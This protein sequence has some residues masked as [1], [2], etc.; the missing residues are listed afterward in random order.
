MKKDYQVCLTLDLEPDHAGRAPESFDAWAEDKVDIF[1][2]LLTRYNAK[3]TAFVVAETLEKRPET[4]KQ[5]LQFGTEFHLH[6]HTHDLEEYDA[7]REIY[8][9]KEVYER[10]F[11]QSPKGYRAPEGRISEEGWRV[12]NKEGF[13]FDASIYPSF[14]PKIS[15]FHYPREPFNHLRS[16][17]LEFPYATVTPLRLVVSLSWIKLLGWKFYRPLLERFSLPHVLVFN[18][19]LHDLWSLPAY[20]KLPLFWKIVYARNRDRGLEFLD[21]FLSFIAGKGCRFS[22]IS[23]V[24]DTIQPQRSF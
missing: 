12:L 1:L 4:I 9:G 21:H 11:K 17:L 7:I 6:S 22:T 24:A 3:L 23:A 15:Y 10:F 14:L 13:L 16:G 19:H 8:R 2:R 18:L 20:D 5:L